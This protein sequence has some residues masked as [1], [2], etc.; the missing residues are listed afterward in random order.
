MA[1][2]EE[3]L[4][5]APA[6]GA[7]LQD[8]GMRIRSLRKERNLTLERLSELSD[9]SVGIVSQIERGKG[10]PSFATLAQLAHGLDIPV[11]R[12]LLRVRAEQVA[13]RAS[14]GA[15]PAGRPRAR[16]RR[17]RTVRAAHPRLHGRTRGGVGGAR[18]PATT[19]ASTPYRH[20]GEEFGLVIEGR[21][22]V[23]L[24]GVAHDLGPGDSIRYDS[25]VPHW[26]S[27]PGP[28]TCRAIWVITPP[29]W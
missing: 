11:G 25:S 6:I 27:N 9:L 8:L 18:R 13:G 3:S 4:P 28:E 23:H 5:A 19:R 7:M 24:D 15:A 14:R 20:N 10:N 26:Y 21:V 17:R 1:E 29:T 22:V 16:L 12:L 2:P